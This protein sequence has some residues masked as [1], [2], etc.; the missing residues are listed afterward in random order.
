MRAARPRTSSRC[1]PGRRSWRA[2]Y[3][4]RSTASTRILSIDLHPGSRLPAYCTSMGRVLVG[5]LPPAEQ[6]AFLARARLVPRTERTISSKE[7]LAQA[8]AAARRSGYAIVD[9]EIEEGLRSIAV[10]VKDAA[11]NVVAAMNV[12]T[13]AARVPIRELE[14]RILPH[15]RSAAAELGLLL[16]ASP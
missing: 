15:L 1:A 9:Q 10:P 11:G 3:V 2:A 4:A 6:K 14:V 13:Q 12:G 16:A 8:L 5:H 7:K